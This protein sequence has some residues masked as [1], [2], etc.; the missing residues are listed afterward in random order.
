MMKV[1]GGIKTN[2][3]NSK[4]RQSSARTATMNRRVNVGSY[5]C[6]N[7]CPVTSC[8]QLLWPGKLQY[9]L[10]SFLFWHCTPESIAGLSTEL[11]CYPASP[12]LLLPFVCDP[13]QHFQSFFNVSQLLHGSWG[14]FAQ[15]ASKIEDYLL[16]RTLRLDHNGNC[17]SQFMDL[18]PSN[19][20]CLVKITNSFRS[21]NA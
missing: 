5:D 17:W 11:W 8:N 12:V 4:V 19:L 20:W 2:L 14:M 7:L 21:W 1:W 10:D 15:K 6:S 3:N 16:P 9:T 18:S 13:S